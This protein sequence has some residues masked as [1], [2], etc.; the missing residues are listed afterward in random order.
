MTPCPFVWYELMTTDTADAARFYRAVVGWEAHAVGRP[1][2][3][4]SAFAAA[5]VDTAGMLD[6]PAEARNAGAPPAWFG[7]VGVPDV[8]AWCERVTQG[9]GRVHRAA[10]TIDGVGR[11][12]VVADPQGAPFVLFTA[13]T[14]RAT[15]PAPAGT[16]GHMG[17]RELYAADRDMAFAFYASTFGW[18]AS[19]AVDM[20]A[21]GIYQLFAT[22]EATPA[23]GIMT[24]PPG[25]PGSFWMFYVT[26]EST[27]A[28]AQ[29]VR[30]AGGQVINGPHPVPG[31]NWIAQC[32]DPQG[33]LFAVTGPQ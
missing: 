26:V 30:A 27:A 19:D 5:G 18:T 1:E 23:G 8:D 31:G 16:P 17:W 13:A 12:A 33:A 24:R 21:M 9:G 20:G 11:F 28:A 25:L 10:E 2:R 3:P 32:L 7:Y 4:Y 15:P 6:M 29:R 22:G 14:P